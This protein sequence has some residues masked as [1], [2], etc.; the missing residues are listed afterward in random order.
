MVYVYKCKWR[1]VVGD[2]A[3]HQEESHLTQSL[4]GVSAISS[5]GLAAIQSAISRL[6]ELAEVPPRPYAIE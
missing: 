2:C 6:S 1:V 4:T 5:R 3:T